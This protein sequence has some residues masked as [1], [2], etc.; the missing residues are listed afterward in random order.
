MAKKDW[1]LPGYEGKP[2]PI[3]AA[4]AFMFVLIVLLLIGFI[5][6]GIREKWFEPIINTIFIQFSQEE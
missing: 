4:N 1:S 6:V 2:N 5:K 3:K